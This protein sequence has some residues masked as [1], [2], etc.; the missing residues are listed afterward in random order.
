MGTGAASL[1]TITNWAES[2]GAAIPLP[3]SPPLP[4]A[5][6]LYPCTELE[7][8]GGLCSWAV[9][10]LGDSCRDESVGLER[11]DGSDD[12][13][14]GGMTVREKGDSLGFF[15]FFKIF[16]QRWWKEEAGGLFLEAHTLVPLPQEL[17]VNILLVWKNQSWTQECSCWRAWG[18]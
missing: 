18:S 13:P 16:M 14:N 9:G 11:G 15:F 5:G 1:G 4:L 12:S 7:F 8:G 10:S 2:P 17:T 6:S 3:G